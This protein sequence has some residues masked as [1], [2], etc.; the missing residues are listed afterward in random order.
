M[1][2]IMNGDKRQPESET[3]WLTSDDCIR[4]QLL[5]LILQL[6]PQPLN[7]L[8]LVLPLFHKPLRIRRTHMME[9]FVVE[10][11]FVRRTTGRVARERECPDG[12]SMIGQV[13]GDEVDALRL[14]LLEVVLERR[15]E[16]TS[17]RYDRLGTRRLEEQTCFASLITAS[18][19]SDPRCV[20]PSE[21]VTNA[22]MLQCQ[23]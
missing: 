1:F 14:F 3:G 10:D 19:A 7:V 4:P 11:G 17:E 9:L 12:I 13:A 6:L 20:R 18:I 16:D 2:P 8:L 23:H 15:S 5:K 22:Q 21:H